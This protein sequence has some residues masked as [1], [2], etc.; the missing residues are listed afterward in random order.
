MAFAPEYQ[1]TSIKLL[2]NMS[3]QNV[4]F[5]INIQNNGFVIKQV[6]SINAL[7]AVNN[8][9]CT[10]GNA[11]VSGTVA[12]SALVVG[13]EKEYHV[14]EQEATF[15][16]HL[17]DVDITENAQVFAMASLGEIS[18]IVPTENSISCN[19]T[20][21]V[22]SMIVRPQVLKI[23]QSV[24]KGTQQKTDVY[25][26]NNIQNTI[27]Q[28]FELS[29]EL[30]L[31]NNIS[32]ILLS[33]ANCI[34][35]DVSASTDMITINGKVYAEVLYLSNEEEPKLKQQD[36]ILDFS[37]E[38]LANG[39]TPDDKVVV[40]S[41]VTKMGYEVQ[42]EMNSSKGILVLNPTISINAQI[43][44]PIQFESIADAFCPKHKLSLQTAD[45]QNQQLGVIK[46]NEK[47]EG[48]L[49][50]PED[51]RI[52]KI[53][54][55]SHSYCTCNIVQSDAKSIHGVIFANIIYQLDDENMTMGAILAEIPFTKDIETDS[56]DLIVQTTIKTIEARS[57]RVKDIDVQADIE[58]TLNYAQNSPKTLICDAILG[59]KFAGEDNPLGVYII[60]NANEVWDIA[61]MLR[62]S[63]QTILE[64]N[65]NLTFPI[66]QP[67]NVL[68][69][70]Q[71]VPIE[72]A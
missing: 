44:R 63:P 41:K 21:N 33:N 29:N 58:I 31:P 48:S 24:G 64:Q 20:I 71:V 55:I 25:E 70:R 60:N 56:N 45:Y 6:L 27:S 3:M 72:E 59:E 39:T 66:V 11:D 17:Q 52:N 28:T 2:K 47:I 53:L 34:I 4:N 38:F 49:S 1:E 26:F 40:M 69:Y 30:N 42:G 62:V 50:L 54:C 46:L 22:N 65:P 67:T 5:S 18:N 35:E 14:F 36:Y 15:N 68:V 37:Q 61:K 8:I 9:I 19:I 13:A 51:V 23:L 57:K 7:P 32:H 10:N 16:L 43:T 12:V